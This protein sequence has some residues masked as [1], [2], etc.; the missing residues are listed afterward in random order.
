MTSFSFTVRS[1]R[2]VSVKSIT[3]TIFLSGSDPFTA[4]FSEVD[5]VLEF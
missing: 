1:T 3:S 4:S 5:I 2:S